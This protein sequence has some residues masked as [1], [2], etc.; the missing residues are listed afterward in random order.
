MHGQQEETEEDIEQKSKFLGERVSAQQIDLS[1][2]VSSSR[3]F[4]ASGQVSYGPRRGRV[5]ICQLR[6][7]RP[8]AITLHPRTVLVQHET[9]FV[10]NVATT[11]EII[12]YEW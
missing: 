12:A 8:I 1:F 9:P 11:N 2:A 5:Q 10:Q 6:Q 3:G 7:K 4:I